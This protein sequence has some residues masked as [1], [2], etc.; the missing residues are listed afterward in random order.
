[1][2]RTLLACLM[3]GSL[4]GH[5]AAQ[6]SNVTLFGV[7]DSTLTWGSGSVSDLKGVGSGGLAGSRLG[8]RGTEDL[9]GG[10][11]ASFMLEHGFNPDTGAQASP[12][13]FWNRQVYVGLGSTTLGSLQLGRIYT[14]TFLVHATYD[15]FGPQGVAA[16][17]VLFGSLEVAQ[18]ANIRANGAVNYQTPATLGGFVLQAMVSDGTAAPGKYTGARLGYGGSA[19]SAD[20][21]FAKFNNTPIGDLKTVT[22]GA[23]YKLDAFEFYGLYDR[24]DSGSGPDTHGMQVSASYLIGSTRF[25]ASVA[26]SVMKTAAGVN[27]G[28]TRRYGLG[29]VHALSRRTAIY[30]SLAHLANRDGARMTVNGAVTAVNQ[31][32]KGMDLG[33]SHTF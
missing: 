33:I 23:R 30:S 2:N 13:S 28:T 5:V 26:E 16:Q 11:N 22:A 29:F 31:S 24:A 3:L 8:F 4:A 20:I 19:L 18:P 1:M 10:L 32:A 25:K 6:S 17:Q 14:P 21:A 15:A 27:A 7:V 9:G 12:A